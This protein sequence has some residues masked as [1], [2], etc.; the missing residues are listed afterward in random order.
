MLKNID[1][2]TVSI[3]LHASDGKTAIFNKEAFDKLEQALNEVESNSS[4]K[5]IIF[6]GPSHRNFCAGADLDTIKNVT[7]KTKAKQLAQRGQDVINRV[8]KLKADTVAA[9]SGACVGGG[10]ELALACD[11]RIATGVKETKIG[12]PEVKPVSYTHLTL[13]TTPYV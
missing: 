6:L 11:Y 9:I 4:I 8:S 12:L 7:D 10:C 13:P 5:T 2:S 3:T 1:D